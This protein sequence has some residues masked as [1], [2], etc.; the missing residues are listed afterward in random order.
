[1]PGVPE[2]YL[3]PKDAPVKALQGLPQL[4]L[5]LGNIHTGYRTRCSPAPAAA[6]AVSGSLLHS[7]AS[8]Q[9]EMQRQWGWVAQPRPSSGVSCA[10]FGGV[11][12]ERGG[13]V[14]WS[15]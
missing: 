4:L 10:S 1:M 2:P 9:T 8:L 15:V 7:P 13:S 6:A 3:H 11:C 14:W 5:E 12:G